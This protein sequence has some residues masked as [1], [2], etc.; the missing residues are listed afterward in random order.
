M[1]LWAVTDAAEV[2]IAWSAPAAAERSELPGHRLQGRP[3]SATD[4]VGAWLRSLRASALND[5]Q[6]LAP[7]TLIVALTRRAR[8]AAATTGIDLLDRLEPAVWCCDAGRL[9]FSGNCWSRFE[10]TM[11]LWAVTDAAEVGI[12]WSAPAAAE[13]SELPGHRLQ[14]RPNSAT[15]MVGAWLRSL[16]ASALND[17]QK[18]APFTLIV[19]LTRRARRAAATTGIDLLDRLEPAVWCCD[20]GRLRFSGNCWSRFEAT[21]ALWAVTDAAEVG[22]AWS[23][24]AAAERSELPGHR[25]QGRPNS[26]TDMVGAW[27]RSLRASALNDQQKLAPFTLIVALTRRARRAAATTGKKRTRR[28]LTNRLLLKLCLQRVLLPKGRLRASN[29][30]VQRP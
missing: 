14:G 24:P 22:I 20:A 8:R 12:A 2:G 23:A 28:L 29:W 15:D 5:Q 21:M 19:A 13:R 18:L 30:V 27:L 11:A 4:M 10:A 25:L 16:R 26:A 9:R 17:Q 1:A 6:K 7:F 3:N